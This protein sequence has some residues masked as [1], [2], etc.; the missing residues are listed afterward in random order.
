M[1]EHFEQFT[2]FSPFANMDTVK[3]G[4]RRQIKN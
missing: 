2:T 3:C 1:S 4:K